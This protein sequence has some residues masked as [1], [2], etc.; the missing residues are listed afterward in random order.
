[1]LTFF[2]IAAHLSAPVNNEQ[3]FR[4]L[5]VSA[6]VSEIRAQA[7]RYFLNVGGAD[8]EVD[9]NLEDSALRTQ[10]VLAWVRRA[11]EA[12]TTYH[13]RF[14]VRRARVSVVQNAPDCR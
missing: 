5:A 6:T 3:V 1:M 11:T 2:L 12:V 9:I 13:G 14:P 10:D 7:P 8:I 4:H